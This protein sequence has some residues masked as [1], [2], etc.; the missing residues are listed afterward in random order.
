MLCLEPQTGSAAAEAF[1]RHGYVVVPFDDDGIIDNIAT[2][3]LAFSRA[4]TE[5]LKAWEF[6]YHRN[7]DPD[8]GVII[9]DD[10]AYDRK[11]FFHYRDRL[12]PLLESRGV[13]V[14][15]CYDLLGYCSALSL[16][17]SRQIH[18]FAVSLDKQW[19]LIS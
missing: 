17:L 15:D 3:W 6:D 8:D 14:S 12:W 11:L 9:R 2:D 10:P 4:D 7:G 19:R 16:R 5:T 1:L 18:S 13:D